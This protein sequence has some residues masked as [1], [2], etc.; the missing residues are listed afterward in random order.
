MRLYHTGIEIIKEPDVH[1]GRKNAD[2]GQGF[3]LSDDEEFSC[4][5]AKGTKDNP[6]LIN[7]YELDTEDLRIHHFNRE[8]DW[9]SYIF[10]NRRS[11]PDTLEA[12]VIIGPIANDT[13]YDTMG[14]ITSGLLEDE[15]ALRLL[16]L[17]PEYT[18]VVLKTEKAV[19]HLKWIE[20]RQIPAGDQDKYRDIIEK[21]QDEYLKAISDMLDPGTESD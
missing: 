5:W 11:Q 7:I 18:Q 14:M 1:Y 10:G 12:D 16:Q 13:I 2:F 9:F 4:R 3:Y 15:E 19:A 8:R 6:P 17:G 20:V 21:E